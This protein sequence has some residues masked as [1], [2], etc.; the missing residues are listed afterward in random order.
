MNKEIYK[1]KFIELYSQHVKR[2]GAEELLKWIENSDFF[3]APASTRFHECYEGG[4]CEHSVRIFD[5]LGR[6]LKAYP[7]VHTS[8]ETAVIVSLLH[9]LCK[10]GCYKT[11]LRNKKENG[12]WIQVPFYTFDEDFSFGGHGSKSVYLIQKY[13]KLTDEEATAINCHM[14][15]ENGNWAVNDAFRKF[16]LAFLLHTADVASTIP[17]LSEEA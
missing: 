5:E 10:I 9:D 6:L 4:L 11:E 2:D 17:K 13:M 1:K 12:V 7:E 14:G 8:Y 16:P 3:T 15:V